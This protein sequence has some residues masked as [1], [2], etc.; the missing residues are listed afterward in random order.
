MTLEGQPL[1]LTVK[2]FELLLIFV[3]NPN[4][5]FSREYLTQ[6]VWGYLT[7]VDTRT[8]DVHVSNLRNN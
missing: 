4:Q 5:V 2:E 7:N 1:N 8:I 3:S 6:K